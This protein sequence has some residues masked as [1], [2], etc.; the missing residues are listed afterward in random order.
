MF[1]LLS[2]ERAQDSIP[3]YQPCDFVYRV[4]RPGPEMEGFWRLRRRVFCDEQG[5]FQESD[6]DQYDATMIPIICSALLA[7]MEDRVVGTVRIDERTPGV[8]W[9]SR[10]AVDGDFR[11]LRCISSGVPV[12]NRQ[13]GFYAKRSIGA[14]LIYKAVSTAHLL[15]CQSFHAHVQPQNVRFFRRLHWRVLEEVELHGIR[16]AKMAADLKFYPP[17]ERSL[18]A[19]LVA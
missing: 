6:K 1:G 13:P 10:L 16:H 19:A 3:E 4:A 5:V 11:N 9:G 14:G 15:G 8:W 2:N 7:G 17:A 18:D 12:R